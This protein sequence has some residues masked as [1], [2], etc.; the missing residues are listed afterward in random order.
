[1]LHLPE[2]SVIGDVVPVA[3]CAIRL[4]AHME[5]LSGES[6][7]NIRRRAGVVTWNIKAAMV[8]D[9]VEINADAEAM[10]GFDDLQQLRLR[11]VLGADSAAL[12]FVTEIERIKQVIA[13]GEHAPGF[14]GRR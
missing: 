4:A 12:I 6:G 9:V 10:S 2:I 8:H 5:I 14:R 7:I 3:I 1:M 11:P 13:D